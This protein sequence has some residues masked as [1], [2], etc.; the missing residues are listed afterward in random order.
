MRHGLL[1]IMA[2]TVI[3]VAGASEEIPVKSGI[4]SVGLFKNGLAV[5]RREVK[6]PGPGTYLV[7][8]A[9][10][11]VHG[12]WWVRSDAPIETRVTMRE[13]PETVRAGAPIDLQNGLVGKQVTIYFREGQ[14]PPAT[15]KVESITPP[16]DEKNWGRT[17]VVK[18]HAPIHNKNHQ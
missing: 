10:E 14:I 6:I 4:V 16:K 7:E 3:C 8:D 13:M 2:W 11:P 15:G 1:L 5:V 17:W 12:T 18:N 9:P